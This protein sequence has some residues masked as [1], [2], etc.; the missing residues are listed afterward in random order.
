MSMLPVAVAVAVLIALGVWLIVGIG[1][2]EEDEIAEIVADPATYLGE[3]VTVVGRVQDRD[4]RVF[5]I[6]GRRPGDRL[7]VVPRDAGDVP[8]DD[9]QEPPE[10]STP[11]PKLGRRVSVTGVVERWEAGVGGTDRDIGFAER[12]DGKPAIVSARVT[13]ER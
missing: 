3:E 12:F 4:P 13:S 11:I 1:G 7:L 6:G 5:T 8:N 9:S 2:G 10:A